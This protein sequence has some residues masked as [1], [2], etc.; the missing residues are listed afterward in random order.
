MIMESIK[1]VKKFILKKLED[2]LPGHLTYHSVDHVK[3]VYKSCK[4]IANKEGVSEE[5]LRL[6]LTAVLFHDAGFLVQAQ[7]HEAISCNIAREYL[8]AF[9]YDASEIE[10][11]CGMIMATKIPQTPHN[12][13]EAI[14][15]DADLDY[16]GRNDFYEIGQRLYDEL[17]HTGVVSNGRE[18][19][20]LQERF[21]ENHHYFTATS[22]RLRQ[23]K[24]ARYLK[25]IK[26][27]LSEIPKT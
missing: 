2:E 1:S 4:K 24:K 16:L 9:G 7:D 8:P 23:G 13:L 14:I 27:Q 21:L 17:V 20:E 3:D 19:N 5:D 6:L 18:W 12:I 15:A 11:I 26:Q 25:E 10:R 22:I